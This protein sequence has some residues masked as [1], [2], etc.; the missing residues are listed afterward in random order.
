MIDIILLILGIVLCMA[1]IVGSF[2]PIIPGPIT[3]WVGILILNLTSAVDFNFYFVII[4]L[5]IAVIISALDY[6]IPIVGVKKLGGSKGGLIGA[7]I[8]LVIGFIILGP[9]GIIF[10]PFVGA[11]TGEIINKKNLKQSIKPAL[12]S[13]FGILIGSGIKFCLS[14]VYLF[15]Y[16]NIF[17]SY[18][19][20]F[21]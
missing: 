7:S 1:G 9:L 3:S 10:G 6:I 4:T 11:V 19:D 12:G 16:L 21:F 15:F 5:I 13:L 17:W 20:N 2:I 14:V 18:R 8:G